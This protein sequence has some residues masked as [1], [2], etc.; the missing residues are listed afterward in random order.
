MSNDEVA[1]FRR[2]TGEL[3]A[4]ARRHLEAAGGDVER[5]VLL[6]GH[7]P[8]GSAAGAF[9]DA[10]QPHLFLDLVGGAVRLATHYLHTQA[11]Q[12][13]VTQLRERLGYWVQMAAVLPLGA[14]YYVSAAA[15]IALLRVPGLR[16]LHLV[17]L[18][19]VVEPRTNPNDTARRFVREFNETY[20]CPAGQQPVP[21]LEKS[22]TTATYMAQKQMRP[23]L[24]WLQS[25]VHP[26]TP[27]F[28][29]EVLLHPELV[30]MVA[31]HNCLV[32][33][34]T[35]RELEAYQVANQMKVT[36]FPVFMV[37]CLT[38]SVTE[39]ADG[40]VPS[41]PLLETVFRSQGLHKR[42]QDFF[43]TLGAKLAEM[44][45]KLAAIESHTVETAQYRMMRDQQDQAYEESLAQ[46][47]AREE[48][49]QDHQR[50]AQWRRWKRHHLV[51]EPQDG[52]RARL[53]VRLPSGQRISRAFGS[54]VSVLEVYA[55]VDVTMQEE[56]AAETETEEPRGYSP[57]F[58]FNLVL[59][60]PRLV[61]AVSNETVES[62][63][64]LW[65]SGNLVVEM[66]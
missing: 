3:E 52:P 61:V 12:P 36:R 45:P 42:P 29:R 1:Q 33:G 58:S 26:D 6:S 48:A 27:A 2:I 10:P 31:A 20:P 43:D 38:Q 11:A 4:D 17:Q 19:V 14:V 18:G 40:P 39:T 54:E 35:V 66:E 5:A 7:R 57:Q 65:P 9:P 28:V 23:L 21:F 55:W 51:P 44:G 50:L 37:V 13:A 24:V 46:D 56:T 62:V 60:M 16:A 47:T 63:S 49:H 59:V 25:D 41:A 32:W 30:R 53:H 64:A 34:G 15:T 8:E 22:Y